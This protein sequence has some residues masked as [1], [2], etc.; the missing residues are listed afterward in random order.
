[1]KVDSYDNL[2][3]LLPHHIAAFHEAAYFSFDF[4]L[5]WFKN[6]IETSFNADD[7]INII[8]ADDDDNECSVILPMYYLK[9]NAFEPKVIRSLSNFYSSLYS[10]IFFK[11]MDEELLN[12]AILKI[13]A[14]NDSWDIIELKPLSVD[15]A[16]FVAILKALRNNGF[17]PHKYFCFINW[18]LLVGGRSYATYF[19]GLPSRLQNTIKRKQKHFLS[20]NEGRLEIITRGEKLEN[21]IIDYIR[22]YN[23]SW[24][25]QEPYPDF[26]PGLIRMCADQGWLRLGLA[27]FHDEP[28]GAQIWIV[29]HSRAAIYKLAHDKKYDSYSIGSVLTAHMMQY[30]L[31]VDKVNEVDYLVGDDEYK[32]DWMSHRRERWG[33]IA[34][35]SK[36]I[37]GLI[38][39]ITQILGEIRRTIVK[40]FFIAN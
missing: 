1:M 9:N 3:A 2:E 35:N 23:T 36:T 7:Q 28:I 34:F 39:A 6:L 40:F 22:V 15:H 21:G 31:D 5:Y 4:S 14:L 20:S 27:Y 18:Y 32:K 33:I 16:S 37:F 17:W 12:Q 25:I 24:K 38:G 10:P 29:V 8:T 19:N 13:K 30:V 11:G 26:I